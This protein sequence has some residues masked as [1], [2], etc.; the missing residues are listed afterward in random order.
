MVIL[1]NP[2]DIHLPALYHLAFTQQ[3]SEFSGGSGFTMVF[4]RFSLPKQESLFQYSTKALKNN[5]SFTCSCLCQEVFRSLQVKVCGGEEG[6]SG[7]GHTLTK[8]P[9]DQSLK[10]FAKVGSQGLNL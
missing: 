8:K 4:L 9:K 1:H 10:Y 7:A 3:G 5:T 2:T 6:H